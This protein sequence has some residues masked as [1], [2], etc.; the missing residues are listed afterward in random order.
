M[1]KNYMLFAQGFGLLIVIF[2]AY[3]CQKETKETSGISGSNQNNISMSSTG[4]NSITLTGTYIVTPSGNNSL[5][6]VEAAIVSIGGKVKRVIPELGIVVA[7]GDS[8]FESNLKKNNRVK[9]VL[10]DFNV[11]FINT[12][13]TKG[14]NPSS[15]STS[16]ANTNPLY[17]LQWSH[18]A[19][20]SE[21]AWN[22]GHF[23]EGAV[24]AVL[25]NGFFPSHPD[26]V[27]NVNLTLSENFVDGENLVFGISG[28]SH[29]TH[30]AGIIAAANNDIGIVGVAPKAE[31]V[32]VKVLGDAGSGSFDDVMAG[33][34]YAANL[35]TV[36]IINMS[37][38]AVIPRTLKIDGVNY[39]PAIRELIN[40]I[41][42]AVQYA[43]SKGK[44]VIVSAGNDGINPQ[45]EGVIIT[46]ASAP[47]AIS[48]SAL[49][50]NGFFINPTT[51]LDLQAF[52]T[53]FGIQA[54]ELSGSGGNIDFNLRNAGGPWFYDMVL[55]S[56][57]ATGYSFAAGTS[58]AAPQVAGVA[59]LIIGKYGKMNPNQ[60][61]TKLMQ[62]ADD[63]GPNGRDAVYGHGRV[64]AAKAVQ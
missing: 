60:V 62:S 55:S 43:H 59:A 16:T 53:N 2:L 38:G 35:E 6:N 27:D 31:L 15:V 61:R 42:K 3:S 45:T 7:S 28:F 44:T 52:Y 47:H 29:G 9:D 36:D 57:T 11:N 54:V 58:M 24:V 34:I 33:I 8:Q 41:N 20:N 5:Q 48:I 21:G 56:A 46:P 22:N 17:G 13:E 14:L 63:L 30:V 4:K 37:L 39:T 26:L 51:N 10:P 25:D 49:G 18:K 64:N 23:G 50:P 12:P 40:M 32:L 1:K 19:I